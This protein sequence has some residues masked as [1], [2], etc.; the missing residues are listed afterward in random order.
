MVLLGFQKC[1]CPLATDDYVFVGLAIHT[2]KCVQVD[3]GKWLS[4]VQ[5][6]NGS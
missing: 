5:H 4:V 1:V 6:S 3:F 2:Y